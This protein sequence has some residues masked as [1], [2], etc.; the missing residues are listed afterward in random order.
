MRARTIR[1]GS[2]GLLVL[3]GVALFGGLVIWLR[4][5]NYGQRSYRLLVDFES[6]NGILE[7]SAVSYRGVQVGQITRMTP[8]SNTVVVEIQINKSDLRIPAESVIK[9]SQSGLI[10]ETTI[11]IQPPSDVSVNDDSLPEPI[12]RD[13]DSS[14]ILCNGDRVNGLVGVNYEDL[15]ESSQEISEALADPELLADAR[16]I[17][18]N[19]RQISGNVVG[20]TDEVTLMAQSLR[21]EIQPLSVSARQTLASVSE[22]ANQLEATTVRTSE[23]LDVTLTQVNTMLASNQ[24]D[25]AITL[26]NISASTGQL[27]LALDTLSPV[28]QDG[29]LVNNIE[30]LATNAA[31]ASQD[32]RDISSRL[33]T[34]ENLVLLQQT[35]E[36]ARDVFQ[37]A[38]KI[39]AD[40]DTLTGDPTLRSNVRDLL[41]SLSNLVSY[42]GDLEDQTEVAAQLNHQGQI[43]TDLEH[44]LEEEASIL[45]AP[46]DTTEPEMDEAVPVLRY[47]GER[48]VTDLANSA[49]LSPVNDPT[50]N[51]PTKSE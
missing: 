11:A 29:T 13:C 41:N 3:A 32:L 38:Q 43:V 35:I 33:N 7:G 39:M 40:V 44:S 1:E 10:G 46:A 14:V 51:D 30:L 36:S 28:I 27:R 34:S 17:L 49:P 6:A 45:D 48:Y 21:N 8:S 15:L 16:E 12:A 22:A 19:T 20:L 23:Q 31:V 50:K 24:D 37:S 2:V 42:T 5:V 47:N 26:D 9:T 18:D 25:L 4:G